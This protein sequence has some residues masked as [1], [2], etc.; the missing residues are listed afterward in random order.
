MVC[1]IACLWGALLRVCVPKPEPEPVGE[2]PA[3]PPHFLVMALF[4]WNCSQ[5][6]ERL[7]IGATIS[8]L[9]NSLVMP[10]QRGTP[11]QPRKLSDAPQER[12]GAKFEIFHFNF[13]YL[14][15]SKTPLC[16]V[17]VLCSIM[18]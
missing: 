11:L 7:V 6:H 17:L 4:A 10:S 5:W 18:P 15:L 12:G 14:N 13:F 8:Y 1:V 9:R 16:L 2:L 3:V